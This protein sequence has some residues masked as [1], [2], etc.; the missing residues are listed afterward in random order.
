MNSIPAENNSESKKLSWQQVVAKYD[1]PDLRRSVWQVFNSFVPY[2]ILWYVMYRSLAVSYW[3]T[4]ALSVLAAGFVVRIFIIFHDCGHGAFFKSQKANDVWGFIAGVLTFT[5]Y[6]SWRHEHAMHHATAGDLDR[7][8][9]GDIWTLTVKEYLGL[10]PRK[11]LVYRIYRNPLVMFGIGSLLLFLVHYRFPRR[12]V[13]KRE[14]HSVYW[15]N[16]AIV[17]ILTLSSV[18][19]GIKAF[20]LIQLPVMVIASTAG[21]WLFYVH[22]QFEGVYW[23]HHDKWDYVTAALQGSSFY[24]LPKV[25]QW[26]TGNIGFHHVHHLA[27]RIPNYYLERCH[28]EDP[29]FQEVKPI[30]LLASLKLLT[31]RLWDEDRR[32]LVGFGHIKALR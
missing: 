22:H 11:R 24:K 29:I 32:Q 15:T 17:V 27:P 31:L 2:F 8:G 9:V 10:S 23:E 25:L 13:G 14:R 1:N 12:G 4:L 30:T 18:T 6:Y 21:V 26:V 19:I 28:E 16:L 3:I 20:V 5:P 7:R